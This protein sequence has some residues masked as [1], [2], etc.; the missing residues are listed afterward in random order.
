[1]VCRYVVCEVGAMYACLYCMYI[2]ISMLCI[3]VVAC[4]CTVY[5]VCWVYEKGV[6]MVC[7]YLYVI[8]T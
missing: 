5:G 4:E 2:I 7:V 8:G 1:M 3:C 6:L